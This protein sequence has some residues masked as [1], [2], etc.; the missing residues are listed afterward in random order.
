[1]YSRSSTSTC[2]LVSYIYATISCCHLCFFF[3][4]RRRH[5][6]YW[7]DWSS[8]VCSSD[9]RLLPAGSPHRRS[10]GHTTHLTDASS[11]SQAPEPLRGSNAKATQVT[12]EK[13]PSNTDALDRKSVV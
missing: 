6:R 5:T 3:S 8:D 2:V 9:L 1:M 4:S 7:R 11:H 13:Y 10:K 12:T